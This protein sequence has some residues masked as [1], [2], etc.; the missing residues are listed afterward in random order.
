MNL[1]S[2]LGIINSFKEAML[3]NRNL[4]LIMPSNK[5]NSK[6]YFGKL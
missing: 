1:N 6:I 2:K 5:I 4:G 3:I